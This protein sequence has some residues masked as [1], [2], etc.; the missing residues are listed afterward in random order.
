[1]DGTLAVLLLAAFAG[2]FVSGLA[3]FAMG[4]VVLA[5]WLHFLSPVLCAT[6]VVAFGLITQGYGVWK[7]REAFDWRRVAPFVAG[8]LAG[9]PIGTFLLAHSNPDHLRIGIGILVILYSLYGLFRPSIKVVTPST[10]ADVSVGIANGMLAGLIGLVGIIITIWCQLRGW[11]KD[12]QRTVFQPVMLSMSVVSLIAFG[13]AGAITPDSVRMF[14]LGVPFIFAG[15]WLGLR[16]YGKV[17][18]EGFRRIVL[19][20]LLLSG[21]S[22]VVAGS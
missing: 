22:L 21:A 13:A 11:P 7:L 20:L 18:E 5:V 6:V 8:G 1:M 12:V 10:A 19:W 16:L 17:N 14:L 9:V 4:I 15:T 3:G 2:G